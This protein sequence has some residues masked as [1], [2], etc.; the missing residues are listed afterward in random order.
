[1]IPTTDRSPT[2]P[3]FPHSS[4]ANSS[5][6]R[7]ETTHSPQSHTHRARQARTEQ[8]HKKGVK[9]TGLA[10]AAGGG[11]APSPPPPP[12]SL[13]QNSSNLSA[14]TSP[15]VCFG[16]GTGYTQHTQRQATKEGRA[17]A[18]ARAR[19]R[20]GRWAGARVPPSSLKLHT[21]ARARGGLVVR[22]PHPSYFFSLS[23]SPKGKGILQS[24]STSAVTRLGRL[25]YCM[26]LPSLFFWW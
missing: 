24:S 19:S 7:P 23:L 15:A 2:V 20:K 4:F 18:R 13:S 10:A 3:L 1:M 22:G 26:S 6:G 14:A 5:K 11:P 25:R 16:W 21:T 12:R 9:R 8:S 17:R